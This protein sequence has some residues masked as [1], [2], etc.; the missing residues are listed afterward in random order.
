MNRFRAPH[1][2]LLAIAILYVVGLVAMPPEGLTHHDTGAKY[3]QVRNLR[4]TPTGLDYSINYPARNLDPNLDFVP[5]REKQFFIDRTD[6]DYGLIYL[7]WPIFLGL[8][9]RLPWKML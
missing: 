3:L 7:Q 1:F 2:A 5:F 9:T 6:S 4:L 8:L